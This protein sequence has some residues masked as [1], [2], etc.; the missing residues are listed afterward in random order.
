M[1]F[2]EPAYPSSWP[3]T[4][5]SV[6][7]PL[8][9]RLLTFQGS[10]DPGRVQ[11]AEVRY[12]LDVHTGNVPG[13][14]TDCT[15]FAELRGASLSSGTHALSASRNDFQRGA[16]NRFY[17]ECPDLGPVQQLTVGHDGKG[18]AK[19]WFLSEV[20]LVAQRQARRDRRCQ[21]PSVFNARLRVSTA[22]F[23]RCW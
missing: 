10:G 5:S 7:A 23:D 16:V 6:V 8:P 20:R 15:V 22:Q 21:N 2:F 4:V 14:G 13:A 19:A 1:D 9:R 18:A 12:V 17:I 3:R 11:V